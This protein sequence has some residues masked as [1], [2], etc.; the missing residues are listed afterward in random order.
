MVVLGLVKV[1]DR[2]VDLAA[3]GEVPL[4]AVLDVGRALVAVPL[5]R[6]VILVVEQDDVL[7]DLDAPSFTVRG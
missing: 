5:D 7:V 4:G 2:D 1:V 3:A 6:L